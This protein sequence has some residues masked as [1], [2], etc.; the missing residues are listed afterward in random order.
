[1]GCNTRDHKITSERFAMSE[2]LITQ[3]D[4]GSTIDAKQGD[5]IVI[6]LEETPGTAYQWEIGVIDSSIVELLDSNYSPP[7]KASMGSSGTR[8]FRF[9]VKSSGRGS[10]QL[11][12][13]RLWEPV[14]SAIKSFEV[15][16]R[17]EPR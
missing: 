8:A 15:N 12:S 9:R 16:I 1:M 10:I 5:V 2:V 14:E 3:P 4:Q 11:R 6:R 17:V 13:R 7:Q